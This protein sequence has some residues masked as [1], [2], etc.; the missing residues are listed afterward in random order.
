MKRWL[1]FL[2]ILCLLVSLCACGGNAG[3][4]DN[5]NGGNQG[6]QPGGEVHTHAFGAW[7]TVAESTCAVAG[8]QERVCDCGEKETQ[9][10]A[11]KSHTEGAW[12]TDKAATTTET[13]KKHQVCA[14]CGATMKEETIPVI[15]QAHT[16]TFGDWAA[17]KAA[18]CTT[19]GEEVRSCACGQKETREIAMKAHAASDWIV[20]KQATPT[21]DGH[22]YQKCTGS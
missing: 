7:T 13:G 14:V 16:H 4:S 17:S 3:G 21:Q 10:L 15:D 1:S 22:Q 18:T 5:E 9:A 12:I 19:K 8:S 6:E 11:L 20:D 2:L